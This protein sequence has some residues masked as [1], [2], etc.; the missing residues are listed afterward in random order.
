MTAQQDHNRSSL[1][2]LQVDYQSEVAK[3][4]ISC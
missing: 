3:A 1:S 2:A 4:Q